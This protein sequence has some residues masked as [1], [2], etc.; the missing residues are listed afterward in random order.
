[1]NVFL[2]EKPTVIL[3]QD[4]A[5]RVVNVGSNISPDLTVIVTRSQEAF[6]SE[7]PGM[8]F[9]TDVAPQPT[10]VLAHGVH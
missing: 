7:V 3:Q 2:S 6:A 8:P 9:R 5:G 10:Q 4:S 1:M